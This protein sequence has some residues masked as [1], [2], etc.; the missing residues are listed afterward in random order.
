MKLQHSTAVKKSSALIA[1][2]ALVTLPLAGATTIIVG[3]DSDQSPAPAANLDG[4]TPLIIVDYQANLYNNTSGG[5]ETYTVGNFNFYAQGNGDVTP[6]LALLTGA[7]TAATHYDVLAVGTT[8]NGG[9]AD[10]TAGSVISL[11]FGGVGSVT[12][13][14]G[15]TLV[16]GIQQGTSLGNVVPFASTSGLSNFITGGGG[17]G[18]TSALSVAGDITPGSST[19]TSLNG[20]RN[21]E[22]T[23]EATLVP[24]PSAALLLP[25]ALGGLLLMRR[26]R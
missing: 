16:G 9:G 6:F 5:D 21:Y 24:E 2:G 14:N 22:F 15:A 17:A 7:G 11:P 26:R 12:V 23:I 18:D 3:D 25:A 19:W 13:P 8:R 4:A 10:F 1:L 20:G